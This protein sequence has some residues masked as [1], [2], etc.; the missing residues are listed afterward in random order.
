MAGEPALVAPDSISWRVFKNPLALFVGGVAAVILE[1]A[2]PRIRTGVWEHTT[3]Q[4]KPLLRLQR[5]GLAAMMTVYGPRSQAEVMIAR[6]RRMHDRIGGLTPAGQAYRANDPELL[7][8]VHATASFGFLQA[9]NTYVRKLDDAQ[10]NRFYADGA[11]SA[12]LYGATGAPTSEQE[13]S[14]LFEKMRNKLEPSVTVIE[15][16]DIMRSAPILPLPRPLAAIQSL[17]VMAAIG[18][19]PEWVRERLGLTGRW[20]TAAWQLR[21]TRHFGAAADRILLQSSPAVQA[22]RRMGLP[23]DYLYR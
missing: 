21:L 17:L 16:L 18:I 12:R 15:F 3:F 23:D 10:R 20:S 2:E 19:V 4:R 9:Y 11:S 5:T 7:D 6:V 22:C 13:V 14:A 8:W 1:L